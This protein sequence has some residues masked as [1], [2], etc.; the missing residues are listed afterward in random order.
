M[1]TWS[2]KDLGFRNGDKNLTQ[3]NCISSGA[4]GHTLWP[5]SA[6]GVCLV[7]IESEENKYFNNKY[8]YTLHFI[9]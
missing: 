4:L 3:V 6:N 2:W 5:S 8:N 7:V 1:M 9:N